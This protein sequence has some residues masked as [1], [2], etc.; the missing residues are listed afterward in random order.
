MER[1]EP[2]LVTKVCLVTGGSRGVGRG[3]AL[4]LAKEGCVVYV[5]GRNNDSLK[6]IAIEAAKRKSV[7]FPIQCDHAND[8]DVRN[9]FKTI[10]SEHGYLD[11]LVNNAFSA[12]QY[13]TENADLPFWDLSED[14]W[15]EFNN[16]G[17]RNHYRC[18][19]FASRMMVRR[20]SGLILNITS[21]ASLAYMMTPSYAV[22][23]CAID[24]L[25]KD[26]SIELRKY[27]VAIISLCPGSVK[28]E[29][30]QD[31]MLRE[32][33]KLG[34]KPEA[35]YFF[36]HGE[37]AFFVGQSVLC[38]LR[39]ENILDRTGETISTAELSRIYGFTDDGRRPVDF[40]CLRD[41]VEASGHV[42]AAKIIPEFIRLPR[43]LLT[44][45][46]ASNVSEKERSKHA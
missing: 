16:V 32:N 7:L 13:V 19:V 14:A 26:C 8:D 17:L 35:Q 18:T 2:K 37:S 3:I 12:A 15:D 22:G 45:L 21:I 41:L 42:W 38:L 4:H 33:S 11:L 5:T 34:K 23:K 6:A 30:F 40:C 10:E 39:E 46:L 1:N 28:T 29:Y 27:G 25:T 24:R 44:I 31:C 20:G 36:N 9:V 43:W